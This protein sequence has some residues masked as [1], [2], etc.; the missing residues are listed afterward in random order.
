MKGLKLMFLIILIANLI[1]GVT[2]C[3]KK[4]GEDKKGEDKKVQTVASSSLPEEGFKAMISIENPPT[5][6]KINSSVNIIKIK[7]KNTSSVVWPSKGQP[8]GKYAIHLAYHWLD[9]GDKYVVFDGFRTPLPHDIRPNEEVNLDASVAAPN[10]EGEYILEWDMVQEGVS[11]FKD[12][13][14]KISRIP[15]KIE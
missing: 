4:K 7:V 6:L 1:F 10:S 3:G 13:G 5:S 9:K 15:M 14:G 12:K 2:A 8:D 11:W